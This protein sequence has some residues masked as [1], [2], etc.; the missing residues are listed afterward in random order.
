[1]IE[2]VRLMLKLK[3]KI[4]LSG[5][6]LFLA[7]LSNACTGS[8]S[9]S[10]ATAPVVPPATPLASDAGSTESII[11]FLEARVKRDKDDFIAYNKLTGYYLQKV[12]ETGDLNYLELASRAAK[13]SLEVIP[14]AQNP[15]GLAGLA[16]AEFAAHEF[17]AARDHAKQL[18]ELDAKK[19]EG[20]YLLG[21]SLIELGE[22]DK[23]ASLFQELE[24]TESGASIE[25]RLGMLALLRGDT[26]SAKRRFSNAVIFAQSQTTPEPENVAWARWQLG[27]VY[28]ATGDYEAAEKH[29]R[30]SLITFPDYF[31]ALAALGRVR[32]ALGDVNGAIAHYERATRILPDP[33]FVAGLGDLYHLAGREKEAQAQYALVEQIGKLGKAS[34]VLYNRQIALFYADHDKNAEEA[35]TQARLEYEKRRDIYG[36]DAL[37]WTALKAGKIAEA[38]SAI[39]EALKL[40]TRDAKL[41]YHAG[42]IARAAGDKAGAIDYLKRALALNPQFDALQALNARKALETIE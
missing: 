34:D 8:S 40:G 3:I 36:A 39:Q 23:A 21:D 41:F 12:R 18:I 31:R 15:G 27:E 19:S 13:A 26:E 22:Y 9:S 4:G 20:F 11:R 42:M 37:A 10:G 38:Q 5:A 2:W 24:K 25:I 14:A 28:F 30:D 29:Y 35:Y 33:V 32:A 1:M 7:L 6:I 16:H 17:A